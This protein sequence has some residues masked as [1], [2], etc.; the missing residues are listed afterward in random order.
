MVRRYQ[1][2]HEERKQ[3]KKQRK[4]E[5]LI[6]LA[7]AELALRNELRVLGASDSDMFVAEGATLRKVTRLY[8]HKYCHRL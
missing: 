6:E 7:Q 5:S 3:Q 8:C 4:A 1:S 2:M